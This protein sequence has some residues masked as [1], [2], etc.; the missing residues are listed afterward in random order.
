VVDDRG[1]LPRIRAGDIGTVIGALTLLTALLAAAAAVPLVVLALELGAGLRSSPRRSGRRDDSTPSHAILVPAHD[2][3]QGIAATITALRAEMDPNARLV[4]VADNCSD[5]TAARARAAGAEV[6]ERD[7]PAHRGKGFALAFGRDFLAEGHPPEVVLVVDADCRLL[8]GSIAALAQAAQSSGRAVQATNLIS[9]ELAAPPMVQISGFAMLVKNLY[10]SRGMQRLGGAAL[11]TGTGMA[12]PWRLFSQ[13]D[14]ATGSIVED[15][16]LGI[17]FTR[18]GNPPLL[19]EDAGVRSA[20]AALGDALQQRRRWEHGFLDVL[21]QQALPTLLGGLARA[22]RAEIFLGLHLLVPPLALLMMLSIALLLAMAVLA[23]LGG[24]GMPAILFGALLVLIGALLLA[25]WADQG[26]CYLRPRALLM[27]PLYAVWKL[28]IYL[29]F[30]G[31][32][33]A[34]WRRTPRPDEGRGD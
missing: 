21:R 27:A 22:S 17:Q 7:D 6:V 32:R 5:D 4:V 33:E 13:A 16:A 31:R 9:P 18:A 30:V 8:P 2:E 19:I 14:L 34:V 15:L 10:R 23:L 1:A 12:F 26:R 3:G 24:P 11:L 28:P 29:G 25:A 20:P